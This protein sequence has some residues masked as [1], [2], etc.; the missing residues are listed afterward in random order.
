MIVA[1]EDDAGA[2]ALLAVARAAVP[3]HHLILHVRSDNA[4]ALRGGAAIV[5]GKT[6]LLGKATAW[7]CRLGV[8]EAPITSPDALRAALAP[9]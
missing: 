4:A 7:V 5:E 6:S 3:R 9:R 1:G 2:A 8:C